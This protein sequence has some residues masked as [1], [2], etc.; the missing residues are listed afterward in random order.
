MLPSSGGNCSLWFLPTGSTFISS[1]EKGG[2]DYG[3]PACLCGSGMSN[4]EAVLLSA[5]LSLQ[6]GVCCG[7]WLC[8]RPDVLAQVLQ[9]GEARAALC[10][11]WVANCQKM[12]WRS[13]GCF[14]KAIF[15]YFSGWIQLRILSLQSLAQPYFAVGICP[16]LQS[17][18]S[19]Q[20]HMGCMLHHCLW[21]QKN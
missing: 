9:D 14:S 2:I 20:W 15:W 1:C 16:G 18:G 4:K 5:P 11:Q 21:P 17:S 19:Y 12:F 8:H 13:F 6:L 3:F 7:G 10:A